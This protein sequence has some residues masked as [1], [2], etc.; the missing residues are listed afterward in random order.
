MIPFALLIAAAVCSA[1]ILVVERQAGRLGLIDR[2][3]ER[4]SH[5]QPRPRGGGLGIVAGT[6]AAL[7]LVTATEPMAD[8]LLAVLAAGCV[9]A[10]AGLWD[11]IRSVA[12]GVR[13]AVQATAALGVVAVTGGLTHVPLPAPLDMP[14]APSAGALLAVVWIV[15]VTNFV[16][17]MDGADGLA[18]GQ[19]TLTLAALA[20]VAWPSGTAVVALLVVS[21]TLV[22]LA[23][24][25]PPAHIF[26][27]DVGSG[28]LGFL[29]AAL[30]FTHES[31]PRESLVLLVGISLTLFLSDPVLT[32]GRRLRRGVRIT[33]SHREH[34]YQ[35][36]FVP[37]EP[38][39]RVVV[40]ILTGSA[41]L[42]ALAV[43]AWY[44]PGLG[45][46]VLTCA[47]M[48]TLVEWRAAARTSG[49]RRAGRA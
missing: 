49:G 16:N 47:V 43:L 2:P 19:A 29:M 9:V 22:F 32:L 12:P 8:G 28:W 48:A 5:V 46:P 34:A 31:G 35:R 42:S 36:L 26:L 23:R 25:W 39:T 18:G 11:D 40:S 1:G 33:E 45:W 21:A 44:R 37:G 14:I 4:S 15:G 20:I 24:N 41:M 3:N 38:H 6:L 10:L 7:V 30:P 13:L 27:G 17:F